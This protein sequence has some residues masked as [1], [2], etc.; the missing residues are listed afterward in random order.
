[1]LRSANDLFINRRDPLS[2][3]RSEKGGI[4]AI[5]GHFA[6]EGLRAASYTSEALLSPARPKDYGFSRAFEGQK[7]WEYFA[8]EDNASKRK[9]FQC[10]IGAMMKYLD[11][12]ESVL[13]GE[14]LLVLSH[15]SLY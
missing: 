8:K 3:Y 4:G 9:R 1:L 6:E 12:E 10:G 11:R 5:I 15:I 2:K 13:L 7:I 14:L